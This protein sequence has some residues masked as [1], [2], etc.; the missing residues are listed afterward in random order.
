MYSVILLAALAQPETKPAEPGGVPPTQMLARIDAKGNLKI[1]S[2]TS[3]DYGGCYGYGAPMPAPAPRDGRAPAKAPEKAP[4]KVPVKV[5]VTQLI[6]MTAEMP[7][8]DV[9][10][11]SATGKAITPETL[12]SQLAKERPVLVALDGKKVD[13]FLLQLYKEDTIILVPPANTLGA[14]TGG[15]GGYGGYVGPTTG[16]TYPVPAPS[17]TP[18]GKQP[19]RPRPLPPEQRKRD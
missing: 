8:K 17:T 14:G 12:A 2:V 3:I 15:F 6:V 7:A 11:Y 16:G 13:P 4:D 9:K 18:Y 19:D 5:K 10:A 1:T